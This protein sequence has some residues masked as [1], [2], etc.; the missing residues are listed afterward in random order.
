VS[1]GSVRFSA[2]YAYEGK[3]QFNVIND[4]NYQA[5]F[6][7]LNARISLAGGQPDWEVAL[8]GTNLTD[9]HFAYNGGTITAPPSTQAIFAWHI[10]GAPR[11]VAVEARYRWS[12]TR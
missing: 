5:G 7:T 11:M 6:G 3:T 8:Y 10:P 4:F 9:E 1:L 2:D 12:L